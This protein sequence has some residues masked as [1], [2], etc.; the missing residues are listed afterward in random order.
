M[1]VD[2]ALM[3]AAESSTTTLTVAPASQVYGTTGSIDMSRNVTLA[4]AASPSGQVEL[5]DGDAVIASAP[6][7]N[8][9]TTDRAGFPDVRRALLV[10]ALRPGRHRRGAR[11]DLGPSGVH[12]R[13]GDVDDSHHGYRWKVR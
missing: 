1:I 13:E 7:A 3:P 2:L 5:L 8:G 9:R 4:G 12:G 10:R 6:V 11:V